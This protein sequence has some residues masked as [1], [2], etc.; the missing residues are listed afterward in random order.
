[1]RSFVEAQTPSAHVI[2]GEPK[3]L[4]RLPGASRGIDLLVPLD[5]EPPSLAPLAEIHVDVVEAADERWLRLRTST[6]NL[7]PLFYEFALVVADRAQRDR[8]NTRDALVEAVA[9][10]RRLLQGA[11]M[12]AVE[13]QTGLYG[14]LLLLRRLEPQLGSAALDA[15]TGPMKQAHDFRLG[16]VEI[17]VKTTRS[18]RRVHTINGAH[19]LEPSPGCR[20]FVASVQ[21][22]AAGAGGRS[23]AQLIGE[24]RECFAERGAGERFSRL[25]EDACS[26]PPTMEAHYSEQLKLRRRM[27][28][29]PVNDRLPRI[30]SADVANISRPEMSRISDVRFR[31]DVEGLG[32][33]DGSPNF[34]DVLPEVQ[35]HE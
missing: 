23:L 9:G 11:A 18:E 32:D 14:E 19:Q 22:A 33:L 10:W 5:G 4:L 28:L 12:L 20:L 13:R 27:A 24:L 29:I 30:S 1:M 35:T 16:D 2:D 8:L 17:E 3:L 31:V 15:W 21:V 26:V 25:I 34:L 6:P 7:F